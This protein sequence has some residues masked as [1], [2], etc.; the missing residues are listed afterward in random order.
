[1][2]K[3]LLATVKKF[4]PELETMSCPFFSSRYS[5]SIEAGMTGL[6]V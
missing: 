1:M 3:R 6:R 4:W 5:F 2:E